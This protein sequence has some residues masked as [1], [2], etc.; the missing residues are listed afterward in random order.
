MAM[1]IDFYDQQVSNSFA[2]QYNKDMNMDKTFKAGDRVVDVKTG[3]VGTVESADHDS[4]NGYWIEWDNQEMF[5]GKLWSSAEEL[6]FFYKGER[7]ILAQSPVDNNP[8]TL[9]ALSKP[10]LSDVPPVALFAL[11]AAMSDGASKYG[12]YNY[13]DTSATASVFYDA[14]QRHLVDWYNGEDFAH[15]SNVN[16]LGHIMASCAILLDAEL[17]NS[18]VD[19]RDKRH[20]ESIARNKTWMKS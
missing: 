11:G 17:N 10:K 2:K 16:H 6:E 8:K 15:D 13:R 3:D 1:S 9:V 19:D 18:F 12:R 4:P 7:I 20:P 14:I 5:K